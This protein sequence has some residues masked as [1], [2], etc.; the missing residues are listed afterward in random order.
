MKYHSADN[1]ALLMLEWTA[2][3]LSPP[4]GILCLNIAGV[5]L[6]PAGY[7]AKSQSAV[8]Q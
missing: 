1:T 7:F 6:G 4:C 8:E 2:G 3:Q 5:P